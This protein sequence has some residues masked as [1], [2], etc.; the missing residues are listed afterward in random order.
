MKG[1]VNNLSWYIKCSMGNLMEGV[2]MAG[3]LE[4]ENAVEQRALK[5]AR[6]EKRRERGMRRKCMVNLLEKCLKLFTRR[7][8]GDIDGYKVKEI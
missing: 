3:T 5:S 7:N 4:T 8:P 6:K 1:E 2:M